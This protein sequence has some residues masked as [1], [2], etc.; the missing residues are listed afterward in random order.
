MLMMLIDYDDD[1]DGGITISSLCFSRR[2]AS[3]SSPCALNAICPCDV[4]Y[5]LV[6]VLVRACHVNNLCDA[7]NVYDLCDACDVYDVCDVGDRCDFLLPFSL[8]ALLQS[9]IV[10][11]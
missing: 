3:A 10:V 6:S 11:R 7:C 4:H 8:S 2:L 1:D 9:V 5:V